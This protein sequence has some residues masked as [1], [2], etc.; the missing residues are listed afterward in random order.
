MLFRSSGASA[1]HERPAPCRRCRRRAL[2]R[3][4]DP[5]RPFSEMNA[6]G[7]VS[8]LCF[9][10]SLILPLEWIDVPFDFPGFAPP[11]HLIASSCAIFYSPCRRKVKSIFYLFSP[12][13]PSVKFKSS[14][15]SPD[16]SGQFVCQADPGGE[17]K[18]R[19]PRQRIPPCGQLSMIV[20]ELTFTECVVSCKGRK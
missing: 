17:G 19:G 6:W 3:R 11:W 2:H 15:F 9:S 8:P 13:P 12:L 20:S 18:P 7:W 4:P 10:S 16:A 5:Y 14:S 1:G